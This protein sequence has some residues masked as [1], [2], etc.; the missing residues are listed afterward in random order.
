MHDRR[1]GDTT[2]TF[3]NEGALF[4]GAMTWWDW[5]TSSIWSQ[6]WGAAISGELDGTRLTLLPVEV[7][8]FASWMERH[9]DTLVLV[10]ERSS[11]FTYAPHPLGE[12]Y[13]LGVAIANEAVGFYFGSI[14]K[15][16][17]VNH[18]V[19]GHSIALWADWDSRQAHAFTRN[20]QQLHEKANQP[21]AE[22]TF[23]PIDDES[24]FTDVETGSKWDATT[25]IAVAGELTGNVLQRVPFVTAFD[26]A[27]EDFFP[28]TAFY[29]DR[30]DRGP[31][32]D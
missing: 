2:Y 4:K 17:V 30:D 3:G 6:P 32:T 15:E 8:T 16:H 1:I 31:A 21:P 24:F 19:G 25:G 23:S 11:H 13:V 22:L 12:T 10:D 14:A 27:W 9:P 18:Q 29:G 7:T 28:E 26:W 20:A 5:E